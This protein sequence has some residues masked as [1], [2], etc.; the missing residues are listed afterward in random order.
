MDRTKFVE[1]V[2]DRLE[3]NIFF[4][5][6]ALEACMGGLYDYFQ[7]NNLLNE[8]DLSRDYWTIA[9]LIH[10]IDYSGDTKEL[11]PLRTREVLGLYSL[12]IDDT[13]QRII[14]AHDKRQNIQKNNKAEWAIYCA[15]SLTGLITAVAF[16][17][18]DRKL[19]SVK[20]SSVLKR[21]LKEPK[22]AAGTRRDEVAEC[23][24]PEG[25]NMPLEKFV[26]I[27]LV[28]MQKISNDIGL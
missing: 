26:E 14:L 9:G 13:L 8:N 18:P 21:F 17:Y 2:K 16:V 27:C 24:N 3:Q 4:H 19:S 28:S 1:A 10:D 15:D 5:S 11:H 6:L 20:T 22:F 7:E 12:E 23:S 25:L